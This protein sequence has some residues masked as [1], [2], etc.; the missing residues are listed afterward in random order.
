VEF[1]SDGGFFREVAFPEGGFF[2]ET[3]FRK[4]AAGFEF[5]GRSPAVWP[6]E[7]PGR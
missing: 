7:K 6:G 1:L 4:V 3:V 2:R 5:G